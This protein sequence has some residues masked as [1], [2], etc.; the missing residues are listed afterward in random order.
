MNVM[1]DASVLGEGFLYPHARTGVHRVA[2]NLIRQ[3]LK[4][5]EQCAVTLVAPASP[6]VCQAAYAVTR[7]DPVFR[8]A[9]FVCPWRLHVAR[10]LRK[11]EQR[12]TRRARGRA[13]DLL[14][15][16][17]QRLETA[18]ALIPPRA[19]DRMQIYHSP[20]YGFPSVT[21]APARAGRLRRFLHIHDMIPIVRPEFHPEPVRDSFRRAVDGLTPND[22]VF[23][24]CENTKRDLQAYL[25]WFPPERVVIVHNAASELFYPCPDPARLAAVRTRYGLPEAPYLLSVATLEPRKNLAHVVEAFTELLRRQSGLALNLV[26]VGAR[27]WMLDDFLQRLGAA[28]DFADRIFLTGY[29]ADEDLASLYSGAV[30]FLYMSHY[31]G[32]CLPPVEAMQC[33]VP[34]VVS[35]TS[36]LPEVVGDAGIMLDPRDRQ[37]LVEVLARLYASPAWRAELGRRSRAQAAT[38]SWERFGRETLAAYRRSEKP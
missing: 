16:A 15:R 23:T 17:V 14:R 4:A 28:R 5:R 18:D 22:W 24:G 7:A 37:G 20:F 2:G 26:L 9:A 36:S 13:A 32:F 33:G 1:I 8:R 30:A 35:N 31:E 12:L 29:V 3:L 34:V 11:V 19:L 27:G 10:Q 25:P 6:V 38:F 21:D